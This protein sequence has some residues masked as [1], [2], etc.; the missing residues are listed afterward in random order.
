MRVARGA[1]CRPEKERSNNVIY[2]SDGDS[3]SCNLDYYEQGDDETRI[4]LQELWKKCF[5]DEDGFIDYYFDEQIKENKVLVARKD[6]VVVGMLH[7]CPREMFVCGEAVKCY[8]LA[9]GA[10]EKH[11]RE[12]GIMQAMLQRAKEDMQK[13]D[14][15]FA[16]LVPGHEEYYEEIGFHTVYET[17]EIDLDLQSI[18]DADAVPDDLSGDRGYYMVRLKDMQDEAVDA[19]AEDLNK[20]L[21]AKYKL[22]PLK[23]AHTLR[24]MMREH[25][26]ESGG[27][28]AIYESDIMPGEE[29]GDRLAGYFGYNVSDETMYVERFLSFD[30]NVRYT[31][32]TVVRFAEESACR[33]VVL[34]MSAME[35]CDDIYN[36]LGATSHMVDGRRVMLCNL[37]TDAR[38]ETTDFVNASYFDENL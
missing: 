32:D 7:L 34:N 5:D 9:Y 37:E 24:A 20:K 31:V 27:V 35:R 14:C 26:S 16:Y 12:R 18:E 10:V 28:A 13:E 19:L 8:Y 15:L 4:S 2:M 29:T 21:A 30:Y 6:G 38:F 33:R 36:M 17:V 22:F 25:R 11:N 23:N 1:R 3:N